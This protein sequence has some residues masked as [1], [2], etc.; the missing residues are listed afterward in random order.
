M[1]S[2]LDRDH[3]TLLCLSSE[4]NEDKIE[5]QSI[6]ETHFF[7]DQLTMRVF[8]LVLVLLGLFA[9]VLADD[10][11]KYRSLREQ[12]QRLPS[13]SE[14]VKLKSKFLQ[15]IGKC[16]KI[17][18]RE[19]VLLCEQVK[20]KLCAV[21]P[22]TC[23]SLQRTS[24]S[25][26]STAASLKP[27]TSKATKKVSKV[28]STTVAS[29]EADAQ[30]VQVPIDPELLRVRGEYCVRH[31]KEKKCQDLLVNLK[32]TYSSCKKKT[33]MTTTTTSEHSTTGKPNQLDCHSFQTH[34][35][36]AF[37]KFPP[38]LKKTVQ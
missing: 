34:L 2:S 24:T 35:C 12:C 15:L 6:E 29:K 5:W 25:T 20:G 8:V 23:S 36:Q 14:C 3:L 1:F 28:M 30:F 4:S 31:G 33:T 11:T 38:C 9:C 22:S 10:L 21:F 19:Q 17:N 18:T 27:V 37:P 13:T 32:N 26:G 16:Q 7:L